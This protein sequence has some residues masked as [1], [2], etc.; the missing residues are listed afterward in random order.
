MMR[1]PQRATSQSMVASTPAATRIYAVGDIHGRADL[2][3]EVIERIEDDIRRRPIQHAIEVYLG[4]YIDRT[5]DS[6]TVIDALAIRIVENGAA[7]LR[8]NH[9]AMM[10]GVLRDPTSFS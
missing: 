8:G 4:D 7:C 6:K 5:P 3:M 10:L 2:L 9:E 1:S